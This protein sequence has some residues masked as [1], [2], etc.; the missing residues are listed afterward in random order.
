MRVDTQV[1]THAH[2]ATQARVPSETLTHRGPNGTYT[3]ARTRGIEARGVYTNGAARREPW[4]VD[5]TSRG[6]FDVVALLPKL[7]L[8]V[9]TL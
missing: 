9:A 5:G 3:T 4:T 8:A 7:T 2:F 1:A 6:A